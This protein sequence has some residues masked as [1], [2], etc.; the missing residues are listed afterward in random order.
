MLPQIRQVALRAT[1]GADWIDVGGKPYL[2][3]TGALKVA[4]AF[5]VSLVGL[6]VT[7]QRDEHQGHAV[8]RFTAKVTARFLGRE[9]EMEGAASSDDPFFG[10]RGGKLLPLSE[11]NLSSV[12]K[13]ATTNAQARAVKAILGLVGITWAEVTAAG[14]R[15]KGVAAVTFARPVAAALAAMD[16][17]QQ[18][19]PVPARAVSPATNLPAPKPPVNLAYLKRPAQ[20]QEAPAN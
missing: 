3:A 15:I 14:V 18:A 13:K 12:R 20:R 10:R 16:R 17:P 2:N 6:Q 11:V 19:R 8:V 4:A 1:D 5:G 7:G 9:V